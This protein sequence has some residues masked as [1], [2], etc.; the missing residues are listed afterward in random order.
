MKNSQRIEQQLA[1]L[2]KQLTLAKKHERR[3]AERRFISLAKSL[4][5]FGLP[6]DQL[7]REFRT[8]AAT[9]LNVSP[10]TLVVTEGDK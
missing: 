9:E 7:T 6:A 2:R 4:G 3:A 5:I 10:S 8:C 1:A